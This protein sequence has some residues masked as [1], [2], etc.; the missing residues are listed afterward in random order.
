MH[1]FDVYIIITVFGAMV[2][3]VSGKAIKKT[4]FPVHHVYQHTHTHILYKP[5]EAGVFCFSNLSDVPE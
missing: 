5:P 2:L 1:S 3:G 4:T